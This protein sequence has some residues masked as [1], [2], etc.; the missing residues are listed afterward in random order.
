LIL[1]SRYFLGKHFDKVLSPTVF[2]NY[3]TI[4][5]LGEYL[6]GATSPSSQH[7]DTPSG[8]VSRAVAIVGM[9]CRFPGGIEG[10]AQ[11]WEVIAS[12]RSVVGTVPFSRWDVDAV[13]ASD[14]TLDDAVKQRMKYG[15]FV[16]DLELFD[17]SFFRISAAEA[18]AMD[19]Q[20]RLLLEY[21]YLAFHDAGYT[22]ESLR[23]RNVG[24]F[25]G[26]STPDAVE[27]SL[28]AGSRSVFSTNSSSN[29][30]AAGRIS[31]VFGLHGPCAAYDT[32]C[33]SSLVALHAA[34]RSLQNGECELA[35]VAGVSAMLTPSSALNCAI[36]GM[37]SAT[38]R[39]HTFDEA[40]DGYVRSEGCGAVVLQRMSDA[41]AAG[42]PALPWYASKEMVALILGGWG[43]AGGFIGVVTGGF[44]SDWFKKRNPG[45]RIIVSSLATL[46]P[47]PF[48]WL[49]YTT[50]DLGLFL[51]YFIP[52]AAGSMYVGIAAATTQDLVLPR[53]RG[54]ATATYFI[55]TTLLGL[56]LGPY[57]TGAVS[58]ATGDLGTG[59]LS[60][61]LM[62]R[63]QLASTNLDI[64]E[65]MQL[66]GAYGVRAYPEGE[67]FGDQ[68]YIVTAEARL[69]IAERLPGD[70]SLFA[71][72]DHGA[73]TFN[74]NRFSPAPNSARLSGAGGG[75]AWS[76]SNNFQLKAS[77]AHRLGNTPVMS[78]PDASGQF[79]VQA[80]KFF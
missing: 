76:D 4:K 48:I 1:Q 69:R 29:A 38:G 28:K 33:S 43:A 68:G 24:V 52:L 75:I 57:F 53:M 70:L 5:K 80:S 58:K 16:D 46:V 74:R 71:F 59:V 30:T 34:V 51:L 67:G 79:W 41:A 37:T 32:A 2:F 73:V 31:F 72:V 15:G 13:A 25:V 40:A 36:A 26:M 42:G 63:G 23:G 49:M 55:G 8:K 19:P 54:A 64:S 11:F 56:G 77:Y 14:P 44:V 22:K 27:V 10:P 65:K 12:G 61:L 47:A 50:D 6:S 35:L 17:A 62:A 66:G 60:L 9:S 21:A 39:C 45:G 18:S 3:P 78:G 20:Q 7:V